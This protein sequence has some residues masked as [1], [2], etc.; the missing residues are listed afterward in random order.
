MRPAIIFFFE[1]LRLIA[2]IA[3]AFFRG[4]SS[5]I[6]T[7][8]RPLASAR[9]STNPIT[10]VVFKAIELDYCKLTE[11][12]AGQILYLWHDFNYLAILKY[13]KAAEFNRLFAAFFVKKSTICNLEI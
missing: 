11:R 12:F 1:K 3:V 2:V 10:S 5:Q 6:I 7:Q 9:A 13:E 4:S 8:N